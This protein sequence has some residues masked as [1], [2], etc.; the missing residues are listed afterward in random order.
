GPTTG[1]EYDDPANPLLPTATIDA[2]GTRTEL[3]YDANGRTTSRTEAL[4]EPEERETTWTYDANFPA[5]PTLIRQ[6]ST[7]GSG[8]RETVMAY[9]PSSGDLTDRTIKGT[10]A[11]NPDLATGLLTHTDF[12]PEGQPE[13]ID[14]PGFGTT[15]QTSFTYDPARGNLLPL[16]RTDPIIGATSFAYDAFNRR[17]AVTDPNGVTTETQYDDLDRVRKVIQRVGS[18][19]D[20]DFF[21]G[22]DPQPGDLVTENIYDVFG[23]LSQT[24]LPRLNVI[25]YRYDPETGRLQSIARRLNAASPIAECT[26]FAYDAAGNREREELWE[27]DCETGTSRSLTIFHYKY[28]LQLEK[29]EHADGKITEYAYDANGN[30]ERVWD[31]NHPSAGQT[32]TPTQT[33][34]YDALDRLIALRQPWSGPARPVCVAG[35]DPAEAVTRYGYDV[36]DHLTS[37]TDAECNTTDYVY[38]DRDLLTAQVSPVSGTTTF[39]YNEHGEL[40]EETDARGVRTERTPDELDRVTRVEYH[41]GGMAVPEL[42]T[43]YVYDD[44]AVDFSKGRLTAITRN[45]ATIGYTYDRFGRVLD[46]GGLSYTYDANGNRTTI[47]YPSGAVATYSHDFADREE[48]LTVGAQPVVTASSYLP[49]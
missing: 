10:E 31:A 26:S 37:V 18:L 34:E 9:D 46:E 2:K 32:A 15:D 23:D 41:E 38:S 16:T 39:K 4:G 25:E 7:S 13:T 11:G 40:T 21:L 27:E 5:F 42:T 44:P 49:S 8:F 6:P 28:R 48:T 19:A 3:G 35:D 12:T 24:I 22:Q 36:Q 1:F 45:G 43:V 14:P 17:I 29:I 20:E 33:Y 30:L 47:T